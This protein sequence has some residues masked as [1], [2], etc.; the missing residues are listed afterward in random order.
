MT[1]N[2]TR[3][4]LYK[5]V[6][7]NPMPHIAKQLGVADFMLGK[8]Y[9]EKMVL[10]LHYGFDEITTDAV[11]TVVKDLVMREEERYL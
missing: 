8:L 10:N 11:K 2:L 5:L 4:D 9:I 3:E 7:S 1:R 6:L